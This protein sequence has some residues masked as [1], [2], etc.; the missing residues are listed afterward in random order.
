[1]S[2]EFRTVSCF[3]FRSRIHISFEREQELL[4]YVESALRTYAL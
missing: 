2:L 3:Q 4:E 1:M